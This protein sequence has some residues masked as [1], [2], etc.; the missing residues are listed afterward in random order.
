MKIFSW[1]QS[2]QGFDIV[3]M[4][5]GV[6]AGP[7]HKTVETQKEAEKIVRDWNLNGLPDTKKKV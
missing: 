7:V 6:K 4:I 5:K 1:A 2:Y 3:E